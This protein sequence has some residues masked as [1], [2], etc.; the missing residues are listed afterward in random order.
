MAGSRA[1]VMPSGLRAG[2]GDDRQHVEDHP[3]WL[4]AGLAE[5][6][7]HLHALGDLLAVL[8]GAGVL[9]LLLELLHELVEV[10]LRE[11]LADGLGAHSG[12]EIILIALAHIAVFLLGKDLVLLQGSEAGIDHDVRGEIQHLL[13]DAGR[14]VY[15]TR[16][17]LPGKA[18]I[19]ENWFW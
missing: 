8:L 17:D 14:D 11:A 10:D 16:L 15:F 12:A 6:L 2:G 3:L 5:A 4:A 18:V 13:Q 7:D 9:H 1:G 19:G